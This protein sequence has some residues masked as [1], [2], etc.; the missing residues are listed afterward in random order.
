MASKNKRS[1]YLIDKSFQLNFIVKFITLIVCCALVSGAI[2]AVYYYIKHDMVLN[3]A[4]QIYLLVEREKEMIPSKQDLVADAQ[5]F[6]DGQ[7]KFALLKNTL[8]VVEGKTMYPVYDSKKYRLDA[9]NR[10]EERVGRLGTN[11]Q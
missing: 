3:N 6:A 5:Q 2:L 8:Y 11:E 7:Q 10:L 1:N 4:E 9:K